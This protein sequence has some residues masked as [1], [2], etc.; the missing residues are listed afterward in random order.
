MEAAELMGSRALEYALVE[1]TIS[2][3]LSALN[4]RVVG[5]RWGELMGLGG[6]V[7]KAVVSH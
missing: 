4:A 5:F 7:A 2:P 3:L 6:F 1:A